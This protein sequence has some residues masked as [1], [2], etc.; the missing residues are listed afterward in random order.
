MRVWMYVIYKLKRKY[1]CTIVCQLFLCMYYRYVSM[2]ASM[3]V[4]YMYVKM[5]V[6]TIHV[7]ICTVHMCFTNVCGCVYVY[8]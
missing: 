6:N 7:Y 8:M 3:S 1:V 5:C 4:L 2:Y